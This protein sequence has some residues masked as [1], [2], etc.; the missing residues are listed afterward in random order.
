MTIYARGLYERREPADGDALNVF[1]IFAGGVEVA[2]VARDDSGIE[3]VTYFQ[4]GALGSVELITDSSGNAIKGPQRFDPL[5]RRVKPGTPLLA[6]VSS[7]PPDR[8]PGFTG[9]E[10]D[11]DLGL[12]NMRGRMF[13][14]TIGRFLTPDPFIHDAPASEGVNPYSYGLNSPM[15][16]TDPTGFDPCDGGCLEGIFDPFG[17]FAAAWVADQF[18]G[19]D[20]SDGCGDGGRDSL[21]MITASEPAPP[22]APLPPH[23]RPRPNAVGTSALA[24]SPGNA[25]ARG[26]REGVSAAGAGFGQDIL[27][28]L[29]PW[30]VFMNQMETFVL[31]L[32]TLAVGYVL[33][34][35]LDLQ[36]L[37]A[38]GDVFTFDRGVAVVSLGATVV[39]LGLA[40]GA[41]LARAA[42]KGDPDGVGGE[43][44]PPGDGVDMPTGPDHA[45]RRHHARYSPTRAMQPPRRPSAQL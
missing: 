17:A 28:A 32:G 36:A 2:Q 23:A 12:I 35:L 5:G 7:A 14:P 25:V 13:S 30:L 37:F 38:D 27:V 42:A 15:N 1:R 29:S 3:E 20:S 9:H 39:T 4:Q 31:G 22:P 19:D 45:Q 33:G 21:P 8:F 16:F 6:D 44:V 24:G 34:P 40:R 11:T 43:A 41:G 18:E 26:A 10:H